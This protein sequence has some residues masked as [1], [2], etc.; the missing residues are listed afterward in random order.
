MLEALHNKKIYVASEE[1]D[2]RLGLDGLADIILHEGQN[3][4]HDGSMYV[5]YNKAKNKIKILT[6]DV[7]G[8]VLYYKRLDNL[9]FKFEF[10]AGKTKTI[11]Y[12]QL[13]LLLSGL[14]PVETSNNVKLINQY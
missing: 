6:W 2:F 5:F 4:L 3:R 12:N 9:K 1:V 7:N 8:L 14:S 11:T 13:S 10:I